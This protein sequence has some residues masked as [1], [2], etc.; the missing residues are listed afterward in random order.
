[1]QEDS[2]QI[3]AVFKKF[4]ITSIGEGFERGRRPCLGRLDTKRLPDGISVQQ[5]SAVSVFSTLLD[6][7]ARAFQDCCFA[8][9]EDTAANY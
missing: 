1:M 6:M 4:V 7:Q 5:N 2:T 3:A 8:V 9:V